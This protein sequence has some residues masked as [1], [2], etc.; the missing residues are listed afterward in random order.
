MNRQERRTPIRLIVKLFPS[1]RIGVRRSG[2]RKGIGSTSGGGGIAAGLLL[3]GGHPIVLPNSRLKPI[4]QKPM[5]SMMKKFL[6]VVGVI[7]LFVGG[8]WLVHAFNTVKAKA[9][10][11]KLTQDVECLFEGLQKYKEHVGSYPTGSNAEVVKALQG[12][13][14]KKVIIGLGRK[15]ELNNKGEFIDPW[16]NALR[17]YFSDN[18]VLVRSAG[19][20]GRFEDS[21]SLDFDDYVRSN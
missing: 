7:A 1:G 18:S 5:Y 19:A 12:N 16:G 20:N 10:T 9:S 3:P 17:F 21:T 6:I 13:N 15:L 14:S 11:R 2:S 4:R 8:G